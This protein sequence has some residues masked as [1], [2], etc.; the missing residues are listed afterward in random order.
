MK[1]IFFVLA[2]LCSATFAIAQ[3]GNPQREEKIK[4]LYIAYMTDNLKINSNEAQSFWPVY[5]QYD[6][7][8]KSVAANGDELSRQQ[9]IL[10]VKKKYQ[11]K[12]SKVIGNDRTNDF[13]VKDGEFRKRMVDRL[14]EMRQQGAGPDQRK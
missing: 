13:F 12:F 6:A 3:L 5:S 10:N 7:E 11:E 8:L 2:F 1:K 14:R 9:A 4:A